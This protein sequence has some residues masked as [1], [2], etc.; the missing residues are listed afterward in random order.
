MSPTDPYPMKTSGPVAERAPA[1]PPAPPAAGDAPAPPALSAPPG[2]DT[3]WHILRRRWHVVVAAGLAAA[4]IGF[5]AAWLLTP[6]KYTATATVYLA[7]RNPRTGMIESEEFAN[8][9]RSQIAA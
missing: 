3:A 5:G 8:F 7:S 6:G 2:L 4:L 9:Q 1:A